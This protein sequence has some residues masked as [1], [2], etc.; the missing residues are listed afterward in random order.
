MSEQTTAV[1]AKVGDEFIGPRTGAVYRVTKGGEVV[2]IKADS[3]A[4]ETWRASTLQAL[5]YVH[6]SA[7]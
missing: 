1:T 3:G 2:Q 5:G 7:Q 4:V 6:R